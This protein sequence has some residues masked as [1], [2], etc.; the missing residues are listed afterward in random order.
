MPDVCRY[1]VGCPR[2]SGS[3]EKCMWCYV[4]LHVRSGNW[5]TTSV[6]SCLVSRNLTL[7]TYLPSTASL[8]NLHHIKPRCGRLQVPS[9]LV[10]VLPALKVQVGIGKQAKPT[11]CLPACLPELASRTSQLDPLLFPLRSNVSGSATRLIGVSHKN[12]LSINVFD[13][14]S[15]PTSSHHSGYLTEF[16]QPYVHSKTKHVGLRRRLRSRAS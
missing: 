15:T 4:L 1:F 6:R 2:I 13:H 16:Q 3:I 5:K 9:L 12:S 10:L 7:A 11:G 14:I 8:P